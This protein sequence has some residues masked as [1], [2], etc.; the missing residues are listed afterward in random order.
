[1]R[2]VAHRGNSAVAPE[3]TLAAIASAMACGADSVEID[4][5]LTLDGV[6]VVIH[7]ETLDRTTDGSGPVSATLAAEVTALDAG[8][9]F[10]ETFAGEPV[11]VLTDVLDMLAAAGDVELLLEVKGA[12]DADDVRRVTA[13]VADRGLGERV[14]AQSF[15]VATVAALAA[16]APGLRRGL[17]VTEADDGVV[18]LCRQLRASACNPHGAALRAWPE[19]VD[20]ARAAG[21]TVTPWTLNQ[22]A[23]WAA[24][25]DWGVDGIITDR[26]SELLAW[27]A[28]PAA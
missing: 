13:A 17:L 8:A 27:T 20:R 11:P 25:R 21:L 14:V 23:D 26:P 7:D 6:P 4:V 16:V 22:P 24:A 10:G 9:W 18:G 28:A 19:L 5:R 15:S 2:V 3:N 1:M 12:W